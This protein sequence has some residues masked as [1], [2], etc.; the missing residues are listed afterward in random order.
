[1]RQLL[2]VKMVG[3]FEHVILDVAHIARNP[4]A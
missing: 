4:N 2:Q 1:M 3:C